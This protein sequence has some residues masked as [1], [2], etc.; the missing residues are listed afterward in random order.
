MDLRAV[1]FVP[2]LAASV[3]FTFIFLMFAAH[4][5]LTVM[6]STG[7]GARKVEWVSEP[8]LDNFWKVFYLAWLVGLWLGPALFVGRALAS[9]GD[10]WWMAYALPLGFL[11]L[12]YPVSQLSSLSA[13]T[14]WLPLHPD[15][16]ARL[17]QKPGVVLGFLGLSA[18]V[19][20]VF[21]VAFYW[22]FMTKGQMERLFVGAPLLVLSGL[23]YGR[24]LGRLAFALTY[25]KS[26]FARKKKKERKP[27]ES[28]RAP[29]TAEREQEEATAF[30]QPEELPPIQTPD[31]G[32][33]TGY[34]VKFDDDAPKPKR[35]I[36]AEIDDAPAPAKPKRVDRKRPASDKRREWTE[37]DE[38]DA[39]Y[40]V[41]E[42][43][44][45]PEPAQAEEVIKPS[46]MEMRL[47]N[48]DEKPKPPK[49]VW[50][51]ELFAFLGQADT[52]AVVGLL[53]VLCILAGGAVRTARAFDPTT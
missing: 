21:G 43:E 2:A 42:A 38:D 39:A 10:T 24:L 44:K 25:T 14:I 31:E 37:E 19:L 13:S 29:R 20:V 27:D 47:L 49:Q 15:V 7:S 30:V 32:A 45:T 6:Q 18:G 53:T 4:H 41:R 23:V 34:G 51:G 17:L 50:T 40:G 26:L 16:F 28:Y 8:F 35:R 5:Y 3:I 9:S 11:W 1:V 36:V 52:V 12:M 48:D 33:V 22:T 46:P